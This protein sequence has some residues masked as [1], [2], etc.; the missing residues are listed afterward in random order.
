[1]L[2][3]TRFTPSFVWVCVL[4]LLLCC[5]CQSAVADETT[6]LVTPEYVHDPQDVDDTKDREYSEDFGETEPDSESKP[7][8]A[9]PRR[10]SRSDFPLFEDFLDQN[11]NGTF[12]P[13]IIKGQTRWSFALGKLALIIV[14]VAFWFRVQSVRTVDEDHEDF[15]SEFWTATLFY[16]GL[17]GAIAL[18]LIP[19]FLI[20]ALISVGALVIPFWRYQQWRNQRVMPPAA[21]S[22]GNT[23]GLGGSCIEK[24][25]M[26]RPWNCRPAKQSEHPGL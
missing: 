2:D 19:A 1:M 18:L 10:Q 25:S 5:G 24:R 15:E 13:P 11:Y 20:G 26:S 9:R 6:D 21:P 17:A 22:I 14:V 23:F 12:I 7:V 8:D 4:A 16:S 3:D